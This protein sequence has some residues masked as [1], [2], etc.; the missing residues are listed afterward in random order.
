MLN[1][2]ILFTLAASVAAVGIALAPVAASA[3]QHG[4]AI[5]AA[6]STQ[7]HQAC[8][9]THHPKKHHPKHHP[10]HAHHHHKHHKHH[11]WHHKK[12]YYDTDT[13]YESSPTYTYSEPSYTY[14]KPT[15]TYSKPAD[16]CTCLTKE[17]TEDGS[18]V[19]KDVCT[20]ESAINSPASKT[21][22]ADD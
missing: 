3:K 9:H 7:Q 5:T 11:H 8:K 20:K 10:K 15:Y 19:F 21:A 22:E 2:K 18:V 14:S 17:Y 4:S 16:N 1:R 12:Y 13:E 6:A